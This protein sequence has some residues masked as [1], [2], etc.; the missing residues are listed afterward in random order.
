MPLYHVEPHRER[1]NF[2]DR[3]LLTGLKTVCYRDPKQG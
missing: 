2:Q 3:Q 1:R